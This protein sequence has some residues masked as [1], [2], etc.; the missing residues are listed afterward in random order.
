MPKNALKKKVFQIF[1]TN[2]RIFLKKWG[3]KWNFEF[4]IKVKTFVFCICF[5][6]VISTLIEYS[7]DTDPF[8]QIIHYLC[9]FQHPTL[10]FTPRL[11]T[12]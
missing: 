12:S 7:D 4:L 8:L 2:E 5:I 6:C 3:F 9:R 10:L 1:K 11:L